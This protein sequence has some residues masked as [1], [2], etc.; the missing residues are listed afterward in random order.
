M[1]LRGETIVRRDE[2]AVTSNIHVPGLSNFSARDASDAG[3]LSEPLARRAN[4]LLPLPPR[5][6]K[7]GLGFAYWLT[8]FA[9][10]SS[11]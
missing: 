7:E 4:Y 3:G 10:A 6:K 8:T 11:R 2:A 1:R 9:A 5:P